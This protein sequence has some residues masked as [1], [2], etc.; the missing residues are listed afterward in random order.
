MLTT[1]RELTWGWSSSPS[2]TILVKAI[3]VL[4]GE[5]T[6]ST[7]KPPEVTRR[8]SVPSARIIQIEMLKYGRLASIAP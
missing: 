6:G 7:S 5:N 4:S 8:A 1:C 3:W 2:S